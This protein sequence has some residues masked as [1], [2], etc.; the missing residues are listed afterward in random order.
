MY[1]KHNWVNGEVITEDKLNHI[2]NG[3][4]NAGGVLVVNVDENSTLDKTWQEIYDAPLAVV[5]SIGEGGNR[6]TI[7]VATSI[8]DNNYD[9]EVSNGETYTADSAEGYPAGGG[10]S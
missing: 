9:V 1:E 3:I 7:I 2:E 4:A 10:L 6:T 5:K 8:S